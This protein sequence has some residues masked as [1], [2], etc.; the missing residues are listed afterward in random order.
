ME[1]QEVMFWG[2]L[3]N[4]PL[5]FCWLVGLSDQVISSSPSLLLLLLLLRTPNLSE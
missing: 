1:L 5:C 2:P 4:F 3:L